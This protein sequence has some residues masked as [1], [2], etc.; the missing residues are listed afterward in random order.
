[1]KKSKKPID[2]GA[3]RGYVHLGG[4]MYLNNSN[5]SQ[6]Q[7]QQPEQKQNYKLNMG[8]TSGAGG[9]TLFAKTLG[10]PQRSSRRPSSLEE[11]RNRPLGNP[12]TETTLYGLPGLR[13]IR[14]QTK[15]YDSETQTWDVV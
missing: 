13:L 7:P 5:P 9:N 15:Y 3:L 2:T 14:S 11:E 1:M 4:N 10:D 8:S 6:P 12:N